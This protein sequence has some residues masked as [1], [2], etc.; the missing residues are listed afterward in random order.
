MVMARFP[1]WLCHFVC[2]SGWVCVHACVC[3]LL[4]GF[5][6]RQVSKVVQCENHLPK[7][8]EMWC[9]STLIINSHDN[10]GRNPSSCG[11]MGLH[12]DEAAIKARMKRC[13]TIRLER[14]GGKKGGGIGGKGD[15]P[16][17]QAEDREIDRE[18]ESER[19]GRGEET[20]ERQRVSQPCLHSIKNSLSHSLPAT[21]PTPPSLCP[22]LHSLFNLHINSTSFNRQ[23]GVSSPECQSSVHS[24]RREERVST[25]SEKGGGC[26]HRP[27]LSEGLPEHDPLL[28]T[29]IALFLISLL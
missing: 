11:E 20:K 22:T 26:A 28:S 5:G 8:R 6:I 17:K 2:V 18:E 19:R 29:L 23:P 12:E 4:C 9:G 3:E 13:K 7:V 27:F 1:F 14:M 16:G 15:D 21:N 25:S 10:W 24:D